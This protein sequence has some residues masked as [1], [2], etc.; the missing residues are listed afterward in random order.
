ME[1]SVG[2]VVVI[3]AL[4]PGVVE[5][6]ETVPVGPGSIWVWRV[7]LGE[8]RGTVFIPDNSRGAEGL[9]PPMSESRVTRLWQAIARQTAPT[10]RRNWNQRRRRYEQLLHSNS[11]ADIATL[12]GE[13]S[14]VA[15]QKRKKNQRLSFGERRMLE[16]GRDL[17][18]REVAIATSTPKSDVL[19]QMDDAVASAA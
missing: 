11:P 14:R 10:H 4:G 13:L 18:A 7:E 1:L 17:L 3:P 6:H 19:Q 16:Q 5:A 9:R 8:D 2:D 15:Q 12:I